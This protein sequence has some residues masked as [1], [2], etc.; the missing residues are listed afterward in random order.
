MYETLPNALANLIAAAQGVIDLLGRP[1]PRVPGICVAQGEQWSRR[2]RTSEAAAILRVSEHALRRQIRDH[3]CA[4]GTATFDGIRAERLGGR[5]LV[6]LH[7]RWLTEPAAE[8]GG[9]DP[10]TG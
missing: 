1:G 6:R 10:T 5:Y 3:T 2:M 4:D 7:R 8:G 9:G